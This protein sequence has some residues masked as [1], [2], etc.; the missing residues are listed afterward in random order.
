VNILGVSGLEKAPAFKRAHWPGLEERE[1]RILQ[2]QDSAAVLICD[3][4]VVAAAAEERFTRNKHTAAF[5]SQAI[6]WCLSQAGLDPSQVDEI[7]HGFDY[8]P[9]RELYSLDP[10]SDEY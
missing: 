8:T 5:P 2:G 4:Q 7:A 3:G 10:V 9:Y 1:Y 6:D